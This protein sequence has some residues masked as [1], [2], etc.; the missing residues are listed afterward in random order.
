M[1]LASV[2]VSTSGVLNPIAFEGV[3]LNY[4]GTDVE[5]IVNL[6]W[7]YSTT[8]APGV[9][10]VSRA[11]K[12]TADMT[13]TAD[14]ELASGDNYYHLVADVAAGAVIGNRIGVA[15]NAVTVGGNVVTPD[16]GECFKTVSEDI[17]YTRGNALWFDAPNSSTS[18]VNIWNTNDFSTSSSNP[19]QIWEQKSFP[20]GNGSFGG[21][22]LGSISRERVVL[23]EKTLWKG[24][25][26]TGAEAYWD[27]NRT[28]SD[29]TLSQIRT[30]L[31]NGQ[32]SSANSLVQSNYAGKINYDK[33]KFGTFTT[34]GE[35]YVSTGIS[36]SAVTD[37]KRIMN[38]DR[39][40]V[41][42]QF[43]ADGV[44]YS[45]KYF[46]S[47]PDNVMVWNYASDGGDQNLQ[48]SFSCPQ[49][50][51]SVEA[52]D[53]GLLYHCSIANNG[54]EWAFRVYAR[55]N[56]PGTVT[57]DASARTITVS[58]ATDV[59]FILAADTDYKMNFAP[60]YTDPR[61]YVGVDPVASVNG[62]IDAAKE[63]SYDE[64]Y[65][66]HF[67]DYNGLYGRTA[68]SINPSRKFENLPTPTR[69]ANYR[70]GTLDHELEQMYFQY[71][72]YLL[73][74][75]SREGSMPANLQGL[76]HNNIDGRGVSTI[77]TTSTC[78]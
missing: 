73:I 3:E 17:D 14:H 4:T 12:A 30:Y 22:V 66:R 75:S 35:A 76:W 78:R 6:R 20:I 44:E 36:E 52:V 71:G 56:G 41:V 74:S 77:T 58:G 37:Y 8:A 39:S 53:G 2:K 55:V 67:E 48:F 29:A 42:V 64:L 9:N 32:T 11:D 63:Y 21:N 5:D 47:Y 51:N 40:V 13:F 62:W 33:N 1:T 49:T 50:V 70:Q 31:E 61:T 43:K 28:V 18:G 60:D 26:G 72:R 24:G 57:T 16:P 27:M 69:L 65:K 25:P 10:V 59:D 46:A 23:N 38:I 15:V 7:I 19:D 68:I 54:M 34:M 45:R